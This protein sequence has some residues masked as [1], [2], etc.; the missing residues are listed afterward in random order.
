MEF[1]FVHRLRSVW[2]RDELESGLDEEMRFHIEQQ[3]QKNI[4]QGMTPE[5]ARRAAEQRFGGV[6]R[7]KEITRD[8]FR[9]ALLE[10]TFRD[11][12]YGVRT[13][14]RAP[15]FAF[16]AILTL[17]LGIGA[18]TAVFSVVNGVLLRPLP[19]PESSRI[20]RLFQVGKEGKDG[21]VS[22]ANFVDWKQQSHSFQYMAEMSQYG[23]TSVTVGGGTQRVPVTGVSREFFD[24]MQTR[25]VTGRSFAPEDH[26]EGAPPVV[27]VSDSY[28]RTTLNS[29]RIEGQTLRFE[30]RVYQIVGVMPP[31]FDYPNKSAVWFPT[32]LVRP[33]ESRTAHNYSVIARIAPGT[34]VEAANTE[35]SNISRRLK[36][37][38]GDDTWM[39]DSHVVPLR[40]N[41]TGTARPVLLV[42]LGAAAFL[43]LIACANV[44]SLLL[45]RASSR[46]RELAVRLAMGAGRVA[47][48]R[49]LMAESLVLCVAGASLG[50][51]VAMLATKSMLAHNP[52]SLPRVD[53]IHIDW[54][55]LAFAFGISILTAIALGL[56]TS[57]RASQRDLRSLIS[58]DGRTLTGG[59]NSQRIRDLL[60]VAQVALTIVLLVAAGLLTRSFVAVL[61]INPGFNTGNALVLDVSLPTSNTDPSVG[62][63]QTQFQT[64][65][66]ERLRTLPG[67]TGVGIINDFPLGGGNYANGQFLEMSTPD[68]FKTYDDFRKLTPSDLEARAG[69][70]GFR[71]ASPGYFDA[72]GI[73][74]IKG[75]TFEA[76]DAADAPQVAVISELLANTKWP[77]RDPIGRLIQFGNMDGDMHALR[78]V[79]VVSDVREF[80]PEALP[81]P[82]LYADYRQRPSSIYN[83]TAVVRGPNPATIKRTVEQIVRDLDPQVPAATRT[84]NDAL[85]RTF[86]SR[87]FSLLVIGMFSGVALVLATLGLYG[88]ISYLVAQ[89][90]REIGIR[91]VLGAPRTRLMRLVM[92]KAAVL[93]GLGT[94]AGIAGAIA[95]SKLLE[96]LLFGGVTATDPASFA[97]VI[98]T[99][100]VAVMAATALPV[101]RAL[102]ISPMMA[103]RDD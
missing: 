18:A 62:Q 70:A 40:E 11:L 16:V 50:V 93:A 95:F 83:F 94:V 96:G 51:V 7:M 71:I 82:L 3:T 92:S 63:R 44:S 41:L 103:L 78:V 100:A 97:G 37:Q 76:G 98:A 1:E 66:L 69:N 84:M 6:D 48:T 19:Y 86:A 39:F 30:D 64:A 68:E 17:G 28:W 21:N 29:R 32:E 55:A 59:V 67:V 101:R 77:G 72:M 34:T 31:G 81:A 85:D 24:V 33:A 8:E 88:V 60:V 102:N 45:A 12:R 23:K 75:R 10:D 53:E 57:A 5:A 36:S 27:V 46:R 54:V 42:L 38:Y 22:N 47:V 73:K 14:L 26:R 15:G 52:G 90:T 20:V 56:G 49:Q 13:L 99:I 87:R 65:L 91:T 74:L 79:G 9:P 2:R 61:S 80:G 58:N 43:L 25:P 4:D 89:R 35:L